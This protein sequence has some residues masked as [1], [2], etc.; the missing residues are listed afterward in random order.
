MTKTGFG[1]LVL[2]IGFVS[3][4]AAAKY[5]FPPTQETICTAAH[6]VDKDK[7]T[8]YLFTKY[9]VSAL[10]VEPSGDPALARWSSARQI[11]AGATLMHPE[12]CKNCSKPD[13]E[14]LA[15]IRTAM[16]LLLMGMQK[17]S[18]APSVAASPDVYFRG[19]NEEN[20]I[21]CVTTPSGGPV[22]APG[23]VIADS[24]GAVSPL[25]VRG[26]PDD[27]YIDRGDA[28]TKS[29]FASSSK[30]MFDI[31][32]DNVAKKAVYKVVFDV[33]YAFSLPMP[34][35]RSGD[36][37][38]LIPYFGMNYNITTV[39]TGSSAK[40]S[41]NK[42]VDVGILFSTLLIGDQD[43][44]PISHRFSLRPDYLFDLHDD[45]RLV[46]GQFIYTPIGL[47]VVNRYRSISGTTDFAS[48][49]VLFDLRNDNGIYTD[50]G[51]PTVAGDHQDFIRLGGQ[52]GL[53]VA[54]DNPAFPVSLTTSYVRVHPVLGVTEV[55][56][57]A[58]EL[59]WFLDANKFFGITFSYSNG[60]R[61]D[62]AKR[63]SQW[64]IGLSGH[65]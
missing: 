18:F 42:T 33:G 49:K 2:L 19:P 51:N 65:F 61:E 60:T 48:Y 13:I 1:T 54:S 38:N 10:A 35:G 46:S 44:A 5:P 57:F 16:N 37:L 25:R 4:A 32:R 43:I 27:L 22:E 28:A 40:P 20:A 50:R 7:L 23:A 64:E 63:E 11:L 53:S 15:N 21:R 56:Y 62:T 41:I 39:D 6:V 24:N 58:N 29:N 52:I 26:K 9:P 59:T 45:S 17:E 36:Y 3:S 14:N 55:G 30:A 34:S 8:K 31:S 47:G 12:T